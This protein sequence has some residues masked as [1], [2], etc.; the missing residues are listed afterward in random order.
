[1]NLRLVQQTESVRVVIVEPGVVRMSPSP[2]LIVVAFV[3]STYVMWENEFVT[4]VFG[5]IFLELAASLT[6]SI[7]R[8]G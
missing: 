5:V 8:G 2:P 4:C 7:G 1:M 3:S 6:R